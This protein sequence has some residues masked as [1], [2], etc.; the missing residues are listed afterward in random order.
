MKIQYFTSAAFA[1]ALGSLA[2][3]GHANNENNGY[4]GPN[5]MPQQNDNPYWQAPDF[6]FSPNSR[7]PGPGFAPPR[8]PGY[9]NAHP[10]SAPPQRPVQSYRPPYQQ[11]MNMNRPRANMGNPY[12]NMPPPDVYRGNRP[13]PPAGPYGRNFGPDNGASAFNV[14]G[15]RRYHDNNGWNNNKF[16]GRSGP[17]RWM[18]PSKDN[19]EQGWDDMINAPSRM[20]EM[21]GGWTA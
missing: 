6:S 1:V 3:P 21:P 20:G 13:P 11:N 10:Q 15:Y 19:L 17:G 4:G 16:W 2:L 8:Y 12:P 9:N 5:R 7:G 14:P 18:H